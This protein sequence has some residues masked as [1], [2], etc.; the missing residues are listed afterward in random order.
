MSKSQK[1]NRKLVHPLW[2]SIAILHTLTDKLIRTLGNNR[3]VLIAQSQTMWI[4][5]LQILF[6][7]F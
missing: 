5:V 4:I 1:I 2:N 3:S 7:L 6:D